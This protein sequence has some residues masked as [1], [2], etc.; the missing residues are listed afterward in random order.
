MAAMSALSPWTIIVK[1]SPIVPWSMSA[2]DA[3][4]VAEPL[5]AKV[6]HMGRLAENL[7]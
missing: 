7:H 5:I 1:F 3:V 6:M 2:D 4:K